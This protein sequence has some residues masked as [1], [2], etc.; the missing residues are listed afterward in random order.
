MK[1]EY[2]EEFLVLAET[3]NYSLAAEELFISVSTLSRH[4]ILLEEELGAEL[5]TRG[6]RTVT[7]SRTGELLCRHARTII[8]AKEEFER[9]LAAESRQ[10]RQRLCIGFSRAAVK[11]GMLDK[12]MQ[13]KSSEPDIDFAFCEASPT[14]L[15]QMLRLDECGFIISYKYI[16]HNNS[17]YQSKVLVRDTLAVA[18]AAD[19]PLA[20]R[21]SLRLEDLKGQHFI[22]HDKSSPTYKRQSDLLCEAG[23]DLRNCTQ[24]ESTEF[25]MELVARGFGVSLTAHRRFD[26]KL[27]ENVALVPLEPEVPQTLVMTWRSH[28]LS[29]VED[30]FYKFITAGL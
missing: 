24:A 20:G 18:M 29:G 4:I 2:L 19:N 17:D 3:N 27:P 1:L 22:V 8:S 12:L 7:L 9:E 28:K 21:G 30:R 5:F 15:L 11:Y 23:V 25:I 16:F 26:G 10:S 6:P 14:Q 13:F